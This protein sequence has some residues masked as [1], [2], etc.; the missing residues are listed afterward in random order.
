MKLQPVILIHDLGGSPQDWDRWGLESF[1]VGE[2]G[3]DPRLIRRFDY[4]YR[5]EGRIPQYDS[6]GDLIQIAHRLSDDPAIPD[7]AAFQVDRLAAE[8]QALGGPGNVSLVALG[9]GGLIARYY[10]SRT[11]PD[12]LGTQY[13][14]RVDKVILVGVP[15]QGITSDSTLA[16]LQ[17]TWWA[18]LLLTREAKAAMKIVM[19]GFAA[20]REQ[21]LGEMPG[22]G[23]PAIS[24]KSLGLLQI[25]RE[26]FLLRWLN[27]PECAPKR[28]CFYCLLGQISMCFLVPTRR[29]YVPV[30]VAFGDVLTKAESAMSIPGARPNLFVFDRAYGVDIA[31]RRPSHP[32][33]WFGGDL[34]PVAHTRLMGQR[35]VHE[36]I[37][38]ILTQD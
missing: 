2:G 5:R 25:T 35:E 26:S 17:R 16:D 38:R 32:L 29:Y 28:V 30:N 3:L 15:N 21:V 4:G 14:G 34:P 11:E 1:L 19:E 22:E 6:Q 24:P 13:H 12:S 20:L 9:S 37:L 33:E 10:L 23:H 8:S 18:R 27:R 36:T 7:G 31:R